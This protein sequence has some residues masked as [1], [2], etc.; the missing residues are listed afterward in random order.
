ML[1]APAPEALAV[2]MFL[3]F[4]LQ[5]PIHARHRNRFIIKGAD[6]HHLYAKPFLCRQIRRRLF[7]RYIH[8]LNPE[9]AILLYKKN[10][11]RERQRK[12][13]LPAAAGIEADLSMI[14][15]LPVSVGMAKN[16]KTAKTAPHS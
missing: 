3:S 12:L 1:D 14:P 10:C 15:L 9:G 13:F 5:I 4:F 11:H 2:P 6:V 16:G 8:A 7:P